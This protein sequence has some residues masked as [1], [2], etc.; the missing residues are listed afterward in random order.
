MHVEENMCN[1]VVETFLYI[2][3]KSKDTN[4]WLNRF[5]K[6]DHEKETAFNK[7]W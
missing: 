7:E 2:T 3:R 1:N 6:Y 4:K 5:A